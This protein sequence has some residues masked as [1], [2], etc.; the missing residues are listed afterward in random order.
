MD[1]KELTNK[2]LEALRNDVNNEIDRRTNIA[3]IPN[4]I[5]ALQKLYIDDGGD[6]S[7]L[8]KP[9]ESE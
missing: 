3:L 4:Q 5:Q 6:A 2:E 9:P 8:P 7:N 1:L